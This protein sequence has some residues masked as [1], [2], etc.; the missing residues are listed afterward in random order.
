MCAAWGSGGATSEAEQAVQGGDED[1]REPD[2]DSA[3][4]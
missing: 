2:T 3:I 4:W 1:P